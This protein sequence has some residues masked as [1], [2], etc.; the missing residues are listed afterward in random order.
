MA[1]KSNR[2]ATAELEEEKDLRLRNV[3][4]EKIQPYSK[5]KLCDKTELG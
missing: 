1:L 4:L 2:E 5:N 3:T